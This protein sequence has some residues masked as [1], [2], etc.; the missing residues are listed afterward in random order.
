MGPSYVYQLFWGLSPVHKMMQRTMCGSCCR[1]L[2]TYQLAASDYTG[3]LSRTKHAVHL[4]RLCCS[5]PVNCASKSRVISDH[6]NHVCN[7]N[8]IIESWRRLPH[9]WR[10]TIHHLLHPKWKNQKISWANPP[11]CLCMPTVLAFLSQSEK[12]YWNMQSKV[13]GQ[14]EAKWFVSPSTCWN[15]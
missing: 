5:M 15:S 3:W 2:H 7:T 6:H 14:L 11:K 12:I 13:L 4:I 8:I 1:W 10:T 9:K